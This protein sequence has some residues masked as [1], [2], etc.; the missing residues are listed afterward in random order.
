M[1]PLHVKAKLTV[2]LKNKDLAISGFQTQIHTP[3]KTDYPHLSHVSERS[4]YPLHN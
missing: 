2:M 3:T 1:A 4:I